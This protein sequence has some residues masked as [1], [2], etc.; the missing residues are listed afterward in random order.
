M[1]ETKY[2]LL[3]NTNKYAG[4]F[5]RELTAFCTG[6]VGECDVGSEFIS[7]Y[8]KEE[9]YD[10]MDILE[11]IPDEDDGCHRP[12][13]CY[14]LNNKYNSVRVFFNNKP[15]VEELS[16][17]KRRAKIYCKQNAIKI[18]NYNILIIKI[19]KILINCD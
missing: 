6:I 16:I 15:T 8:E 18:L 2:S 1:I 9:N 12:C 17:I 14:N 5:E 19:E 3:I 7:L 13:V 11:H 10:F 4:N